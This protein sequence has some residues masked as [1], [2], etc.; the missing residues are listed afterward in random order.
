[1]N[2]AARA[3]TA[4]NVI[5]ADARLEDANEQLVQAF[6]RRMYANPAEAYGVV[7]GAFVWPPASGET[8]DQLAADA[9]NLAY[10]AEGFKRFQYLAAEQ[11]F[12]WLEADAYEA[13]READDREWEGVGSRRRRAEGMR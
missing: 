13:A 11:C 9:A 8:I 1:M 10:D 5:L 4:A 2:T 6:A 7:T 12:V 3:A